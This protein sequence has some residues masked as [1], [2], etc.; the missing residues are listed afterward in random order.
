[1]GLLRGFG[2]FIAILI[3]I[4]GIIFFPYG[5]PAIIGAIIMMWALHKGGQ[6]TAMKK[7]LKALREIQEENQRREIEK[8]TKDALKRKSELDK[9]LG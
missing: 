9:D 5:I 3:L 1:M 6:V 2:Y 4:A 7:N 8:E